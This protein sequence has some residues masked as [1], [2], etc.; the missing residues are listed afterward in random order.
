M[1]KQAT[2]GNARHDDLHTGHEHGWSIQSAHATSEGRVLYVRCADCG[3]WR[4]DLENRPEAP[5]SAI[6]T[7]LAGQ[8]S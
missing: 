3:M 1:T 6:S 7:G 5:P 4:V 8:S 2:S